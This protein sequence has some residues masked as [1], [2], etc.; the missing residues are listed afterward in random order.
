MEKTQARETEK[1]D[2]GPQ[3]CPINYLH[4]L[5]QNP[6]LCFLIYKVRFEIAPTSQGCSDVEWMTAVGILSVFS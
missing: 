3:L 5:G 6:F 4:N 1:P 2:F